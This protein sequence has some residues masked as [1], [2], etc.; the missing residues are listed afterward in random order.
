MDMKKTTLPRPDN[1]F[2]WNIK[3]YNSPCRQL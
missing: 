2:R 3:T 1:R